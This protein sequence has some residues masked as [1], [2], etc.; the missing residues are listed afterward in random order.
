MMLALIKK[1]FKFHQCRRCTERFWFNKYQRTA[2][3]FK[4]CPKNLR[5]D[6]APVEF[7]S[8]PD[9]KIIEIHHEMN[10]KIMTTFLLTGALPLIEAASAVT[11]LLCD[12]TLGVAYI[13]ND[14]SD[15][16]D[17]VKN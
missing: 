17:I 8:S 3:S 11:E 16:N 13:R 9:V 4:R 5:D 14:M 1:I 2:C 15:L 12:V 6:Y 10:D 7:Y